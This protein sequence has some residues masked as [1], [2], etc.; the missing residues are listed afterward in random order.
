MHPM[1]LDATHHLVVSV[2]DE[3]VGDEQTNHFHVK[4]GDVSWK[5][6]KKTQTTSHLEKRIGLPYGFFSSDFGHAGWRKKERRGWTPPFSAKTGVLIPTRSPCVCVCSHLY[7]PQQR[8]HVHL[9]M[10]SIRMLDHPSVRNMHRKSCARGKSLKG[11][12]SNRTS[13]VAPTRLSTI[14]RKHESQPNE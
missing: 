12:G 5:R 9:F 10:Q 7:P 11:K 1:Q 6:R 13:P 4:T 3:R 8:V 14:K 2:R